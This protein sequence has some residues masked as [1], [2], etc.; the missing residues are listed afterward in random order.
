[1]T[2]EAAIKRLQK[3]A[4]EEHHK[5]RKTL[6]KK[7][8]KLLEEAGEFAAAYLM[9]CGSKGTK[10]TFEEITDNVLEEGVD[11]SLVILS[12]LFRHG[13]TIEELTEKLQQKMNKWENQIHKG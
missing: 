3:I 2:I 4:L 8:I 11:V 5:N 12:V 6:D 1:M 9:R 7:V 13:F 10:K